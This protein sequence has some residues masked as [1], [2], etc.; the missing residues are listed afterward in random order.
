MLLVC[1]MFTNVSS[2]V[3]LKYLQAGPYA[4]VGMGKERVLAL[5]PH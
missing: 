1:S 5:Y 3:I 2:V 4:D